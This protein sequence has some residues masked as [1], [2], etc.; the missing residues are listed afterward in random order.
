MTKFLTWPPHAD[1]EVTKV[2]LEDWVKSY[3]RNDY[4][5]WAIV[6]KNN[7]GEPIGSISAVGMQYEGRLKSS[8]RNNQ[9]ICDAD[10]YALL[11]NER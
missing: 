11:R 9:G 4:Y 3:E 6:P 2:V 10:W 8:D 5:Q 7:G 1:V